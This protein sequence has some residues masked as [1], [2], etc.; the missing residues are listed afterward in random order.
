MKIYKSHLK[1]IRFVSLAFCLTLV[2]SV[3]AGCSKNSGVTVRIPLDSVP[4]CFD[5]QIASGTDLQNIINNCFEGLVRIDDSGKIVSGVAKSWSISS[6]GLTYTF[7]LRSDATWRLPSKLEDMLGD[8]YKKTFDTRV[9]ADDFVFAIE[10]ALNEN[11]NAPFVHLLACVDYVR[12]EGDTTLVIALHEPNVNFLTTL[13]SPICMPC[14]EEFFNAT[15]GRY[16][17]EAKL[18]MSNGPYYVGTVDSENG[19]ALY[20]NDSYKGEYKAIASS[21]KFIPLSSFASSSSEGDENSSVTVPALTDLLLSDDGGY[22][23]APLSSDEAEALGD[24]LTI[25]RY[26]NTVKIFCFNTAKEAVAISDLRLA[27]A[28]ATDTS[29]LGE[30]SSTAEGLVPSCCVLTAGVS[31]RAGSNVVSAPQYD[32]NRASE[33]LQKNSGQSGEDGEATSAIP[34]QIDLTLICLKSDENGVKQVVQDWQKVFGVALS[35]TMNTYETQDELDKAITSGAYDIAYTKLSAFEFL[36]SEFLDRFTS[37][38]GYN[39]INL[40]DNTYD[41]LMSE[42]WSSSSE[43]ELTANLK[44]CEIYLI[45]NAY[46]IPTVTADSYLAKAEDAT[47]ISVRPSGT[48]Y[49]LYK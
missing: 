22:S 25:E 26:K 3:F 27:L 46:F 4:T 33:I 2:L 36:A 9:T 28:H 10:R 1:Y 41:N 35:V 34:S 32:L 48:V 29:K 21:A 45:E 47:E 42:V 11:T 17:L 37:G 24:S 20:S 43:T 6:D 19:I 14:N 12:A 7:N 18:I 49:A 5:P 13:A 8:D 31:Y 30:T 39:S 15:A 44:A 23:I 40:N 38:S 16:G